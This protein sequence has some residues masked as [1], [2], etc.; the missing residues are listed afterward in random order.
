[1]VKGIFDPS[2]LGQKDPAPYGA[3]I[4]KIIP[5]NCREVSITLGTPVGN[6]YK[7][8]Y[9]LKAGTDLEVANEVAHLI[10]TE[11]NNRPGVAFKSVTV[12]LR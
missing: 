12:E 2:Q 9:V 6:E 7:K 11:F 4:L 1:M 3:Q 10:I 5:T 8:K